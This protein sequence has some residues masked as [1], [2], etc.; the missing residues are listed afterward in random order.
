MGAR[1]A[2]WLITSIGRDCR[3]GALLRVLLLLRKVTELLN[4]VLRLL[5]RKNMMIMGRYVTARTPTLAFQRCFIRWP[6]AREESARLLREAYARFSNE[7]LR[8]WRNLSTRRR[9]ST[10]NTALCA[11]MERV[12]LG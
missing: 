12:Y 1:L 4:Q 10:L 11:R 8:C 6:M 3:F 9:A 7:K 2:F 5:Q